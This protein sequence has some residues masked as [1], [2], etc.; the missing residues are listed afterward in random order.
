MGDESRPWRLALQT[1]RD[2]VGGRVP[3]T[4]PTHF[5]EAQ[6]LCGR[7]G[8]GKLLPGLPPASQRCLLGCWLSWL[9]WQL[10]QPTPRTQ[11][12]LSGRW[13]PVLL[14]PVALVPSL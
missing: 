6:S 12:R 11:H 4:L 9:P 10:T 1:H 5:C 14:S 7:A 3:A 13:L 8:G 2:F